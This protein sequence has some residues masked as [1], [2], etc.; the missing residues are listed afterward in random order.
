MASH[1]TRIESHSSPNKESTA[2][3]LP[4]GAGVFFDEVL[5]RSVVAGEFSDNGF[6]V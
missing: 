4:V 6:L 3:R 5:E 1:A 2:S